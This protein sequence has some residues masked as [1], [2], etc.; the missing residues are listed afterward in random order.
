MSSPFT[1]SVV[2]TG[3]IC[4]SPMGEVMI[5]DALTRAGLTDVV[6]ES[7]GTGDWHVGGGADH[8]AEEVISRS[9]LDLSGHRAS[10]FTRGDFS[11]V[12]LVLALDDSH[13]RT[14]NRLAPDEGARAK[15]H[16]LRSF[17]PSAVATGDLDVNDPYYGDY[18]DFEITFSNISSATPGIVDFVRS[19]V[20]G[21][22]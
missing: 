17:D 7:A 22:R 10:Q 14:L 16:L 15:I 3:N 9:G 1:I 18:R 4:R 12:D 19:Q 2:C 8:R 5:K 13:L 20:D 21:A 11:R 6:V